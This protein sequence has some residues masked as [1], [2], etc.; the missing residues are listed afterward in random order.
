[1]RQQTIAQ[2]QVEKIARQLCTAAGEDPNP[3][4]RFVAEL[5]PASQHASNVTRHFF[6][7]AWK[8]CVREATRLARAG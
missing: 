2:F 3:V 8:L 1:M 7:P 6:I 5:S 4:L